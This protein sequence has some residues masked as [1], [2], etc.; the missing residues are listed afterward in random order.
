MDL[1]RTSSIQ[2]IALTL[3]HNQYQDS[4]SL[5]MSKST[6]HIPKLVLLSQ[7]QLP[8]YQVSLEVKS[9]PVYPIVPVGSKACFQ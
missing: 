2:T 1:W 8:F 4:Y 6:Y 5:C 9:T 7:A 3:L